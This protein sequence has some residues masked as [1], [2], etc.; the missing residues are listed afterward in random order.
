MKLIFLA[1]ATLVACNVTDDRPETLAYITETIL[2][3][4][5]GT[6]ECHSAMKAEKNYVFDSVDAARK[7]LQ[8]IVATCDEPPCTTAPAASYLLTVITQQDVEGNRMPLDVP[9]ANKDVVLIEQWILD[10][11]PGLVEP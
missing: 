4:S 6:A 3:P 8:D 2:K 5:C 10:G 7:S 11:S 9:L 1:F